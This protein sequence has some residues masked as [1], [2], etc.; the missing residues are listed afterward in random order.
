MIFLKLQF[1]ANSAVTFG[2]DS[3][4]APHGFKRY[5]PYMTSKQGILVIHLSSSF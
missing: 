4:D 3:V 2:S 5:L 1:V